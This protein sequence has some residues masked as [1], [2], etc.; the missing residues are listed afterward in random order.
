MEKNS[1]HERKEVNKFV[2]VLVAAL[3]LSFAGCRTLGTYDPVKTEQ[4]KA[5]VKPLVT[6][7]ARRGVLKNP[8]ARTY[9]ETIAGILEEMRDNKN[10][11]PVYL[12]VAL[13]KAFAGLPKD[14]EWSGYVIDAKN[15]LLALYQI[16]WQKKAQVALSEDEWGY[17]LTDFFAAALRQALVDSED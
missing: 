2:V 3:C 6:S 17:H 14:E 7:L 9:V 12:N 16:F 5:A 1:K 11:D 4:V 8:D 13:D 10:F 15:T